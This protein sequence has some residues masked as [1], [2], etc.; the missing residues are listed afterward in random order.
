MSL[1]IRSER[2][3]IERLSTV[4]RLS[5]VLRVCPALRVSYVS[6]HPCVTAM[7]GRAYLKLREG[8]TPASDCGSDRSRP[9]IRRSHP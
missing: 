4:A 8:I 3:Y 2:F 7:E 5:C 9:R 6:S 1:V